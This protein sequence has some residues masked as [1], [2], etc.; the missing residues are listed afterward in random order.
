MSFGYPDSR[1]RNVIGERDPRIGCR[2]EARAN[3][4]YTRG[5]SEGPEPRA[6][7]DALVAA[8]DA[9]IVIVTAA[10]DDERAGCVVGFATQVAIEPPRFL[11]C[12]SRANHT[13]GVARRAHH[14]GVHLVDRENIALAQLF[15]AETGDEMDKFSW[16]RWYV[17]PHGAPLLEEAAAWFVG[18][19]V[20]RHDFGDH[21]GV[22]LA[23]EYGAG[24]GAPVTALRYHD[25][26]DLEPGHPS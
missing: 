26:A 7:F 13:Y 14:L 19:V 1:Y 23:P 24:P 17:G 15:G 18:R 2:G 10:V 21:E 25:V 12:V 16:C 5:M 11:V 22:V 4:C 20:A 6:A 9:P 3:H 8:A